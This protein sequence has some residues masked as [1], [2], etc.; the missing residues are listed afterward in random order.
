M[1]APAPAEAM[2]L[3][4]HD[5][6]AHFPPE[7]LPASTAEIE[8]L[9]RVAGQD[10]ALEAITFGLRV[11]ADGF[12]I[13]ISGPRASGRNTAARRLV[14]EAAAGHPP[15]Q[16]WCYL[17]NFDDPYRPRAVALPT[18][19]GD[20]LQR[21]LAALVETLR[22]ELPTI[23]DDDS[24]DQR[25]KQVLQPIVAERE[26][27]LEQLQAG[28]AARGFL[29]SLTPSGVV[30]VPRGPEGQPIPPDAFAQLPDDVREQLEARGRE[31]QEEANRTV[32]ELRRLDVRARDA[33]EALDREIAGFAVGPALDDLRIQYP[34]QP[35]RDHFQAM[36]KDILDN[37][38]ALKPAAAAQPLPPGVPDPLAE[39][40]DALFRRYE[41]NLFITHGE[42][43]AEHA[44]VIDETQPTFYN[45][46]GRLDY[47]QRFGG[48][49]TDFTLIRSGALHLA[50]G[51]Y[52]I[53]QA[54]DLLSD[55]R[56]WLKLKRSLRTKQIR[57][58][59]IDQIAA[60]VP[61]ANLIPEPIPL[62]VK[63]ILVGSPLTLALLEGADPDFST[64]F[65][66]RAQFEPDTPVDE[67][68]IRS[69]AAFVRQSCD[70]CTLR[71]F[72]RDALVEVLRYGTRLTGRQDRLTAR[73]GAV[74]D[75]CEEANQLAT[76]EDAPTIT[77][78]HVGRALAGIARRSDLVPTR[79]RR[80]IAEGSLHIE[81][82][83]H[84][85]GQ[86]N[87]LAVFQ[88]GAHAFGTPSRITC[89]TGAGTLG[90]V[91]IEREVE[92]SGAIHTKGVLVL[93][94]FLIGTFG[95]QHPLSFSA[96]LTF[97]QSYDEV[98]GDSASSAELYAI[99]T[100]LARVPM[101]QDIAV[102]GSI[103]QFGNIQP[104][105][106]V[107]E[108]V[109]GFFDVC[110]ETGLTGSQGVII[111][112]TNRVSLTLRQDVVQAVE[113]GRFHLWTVQRVEEGLHLLTGLEAG[114][115]NDD[116]V[117]PPGTIFRRVTDALA[118]MRP[119]PARPALV[120][121]ATLTA[122]DSVEPGP[123]AADTDTPPD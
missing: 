90:V 69:Y 84:V 36:Q 37:V 78:D 26:Q 112:D 45:L 16:D 82:S 55:P 94:G 122:P 54:E 24:Y 47:Q 1:T 101:R 56:S 4:A 110:A 98:D 107:T 92:R 28:A 118:A 121:P 81:T 97:E 100:S 59:D 106:G 93:N 51:G 79:L 42:Q 68:A 123:I 95:R 87:G 74:Q 57:V 65:K 27:R 102:T 50:N 38:V 119:A 14:H 105:G 70:E 19:T 20:D 72:T 32:R 15:V 63:V 53:L 7:F 30:S 40:R 12:N 2:E 58:E 23:F 75:L 34:Q 5:L 67:S 120:P 11:D 104:V 103:D 41:V 116:G 108:K 117:Y 52:L 83:G 10:R 89:R 80:A 3:H 60:P 44:P 31:L 21:D 43:P 39:R 66:I 73:Y 49:T 85:I 61:V 88:I 113:Q 71:H 13:A 33:L 86:V 99:L 25:R 46:F 29:I 109:E 6:H 62:N 76:A 96:S 8:P 9:A 22:Q 115:P 77:A 35:L 18:A 17:Y 91:N 48:M 111:P 64:L 114:R